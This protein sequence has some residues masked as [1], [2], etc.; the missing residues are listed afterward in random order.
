M[1]TRPK[2]FHFLRLS[3]DAFSVANILSGR[4]GDFK[5][6][7]VYRLDASII[8]AIGMIKQTASIS[9]TSLNFIKQHGA[10]THK[11]A[12]FILAAVRTCYFTVGRIATSYSFCI[13][14][15]I[16]I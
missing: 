12:I 1:K 16:S 13:N 4:T 6:L 3:N 11:T 10:G 9:E 2:R 7:Q 15:C 5:S 14:D 8:R